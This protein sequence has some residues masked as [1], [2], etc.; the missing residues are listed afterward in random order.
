MLAGWLNCF[1]LVLGMPIVYS[2]TSSPSHSD[3]QTEWPG[4]YGEFQLLPPKFQ[5]FRTEQNWAGATPCTPD[6]D[7]QSPLLCGNCSPPS[8]SKCCVLKSQS[9][10]QEALLNPHRPLVSAPFPRAL[11]YFYSLR[12]SSHSSGAGRGGVHLALLLTQDKRA[13]GPGRFT[14]AA[15]GFQNSK[16]FFIT[17]T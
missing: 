16:L 9:G 6:L 4:C 7:P 5:L 8:L 12:A 13:W 11:G 1:A 3:P 10:V 14:L 17:A 2:Y 15:R